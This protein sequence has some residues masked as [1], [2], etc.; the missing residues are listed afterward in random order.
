VPYIDPTALTLV[1]NDRTL[2]VQTPFWSVTHDLDRGGAP[3]A[4]RFVHAGDDNVLAEP[5]STRV[6]RQTDTRSKAMVQI[7][8]SPGTIDVTFEG[9]LRDEEDAS[10]IGFRTIYRYSPYWVRR[11]VQLTLPDGTRAARVSPLSAT[12]DGRFTHWSGAHDPRTKPARAE[13][14]LGPH[15]DQEDGEVPG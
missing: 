15:Y 10:P 1:R 13:R 6:D 7:E 3:V 11:E 8:E 12:F 9:S 2:S 5:V 4:I 14:V